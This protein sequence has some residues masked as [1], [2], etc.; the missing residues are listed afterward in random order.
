MAKEDD[1]DMLADVKQ[2]SAA[3]AAAGQAILSFESQLQPIDRYA[4]RFLELWDPIIDQTIMES[5]VRF[6]ESDGSW[7]VL[8][9]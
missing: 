7:I 3:A 4:I 6:E 5:E 8:K 2:M 1:V 9:N